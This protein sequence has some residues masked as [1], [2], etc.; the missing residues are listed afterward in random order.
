MVKIVKESVNSLELKL[1]DDDLFAVGVQVLVY[2]THKFTEDFLH[3]IRSQMI[4]D[5]PH[6]LVVRVMLFLQ[7]FVPVLTP[8]FNAH[9]HTWFD[10]YA[11]LTFDST[12]LLS[13]NV[14]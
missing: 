11:P 14:S 9:F 10:I 6:L 1:V 3:Q 7:P 12:G 5:F 2:S 13:I 4:I 8:S